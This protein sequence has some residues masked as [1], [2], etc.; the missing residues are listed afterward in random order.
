MP[1]RNWIVGADVCSR[2]IQ[3]EV[4]LLGFY[5]SVEFGLIQGISSYGEHLC[6]S[7]CPAAWVEVLHHSHVGD[8]NSPILSSVVVLLVN[9]NFIQ[10]VIIFLL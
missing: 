6:L 5:H 10:G 8:Q 3:V 9:K 2:Q 4:L 1:K 7:V